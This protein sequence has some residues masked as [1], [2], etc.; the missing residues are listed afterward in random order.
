MREV[1]KRMREVQENEGR[2]GEEGRTEEGR[3][4]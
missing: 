3:T 4:E 1:L 2:T